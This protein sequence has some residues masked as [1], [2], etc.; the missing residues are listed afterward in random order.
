MQNKLEEIELLKKALARERAARKQAEQ[1][2]EKKSLEVYDANQQLKVLNEQLEDDVSV[3]SSQILKTES[4][5]QDLIGSASDVIFKTDNEGT[6]TYI[7]SVAEELSGFTKDD[8][9][10]NNFTFLVRDDYKVV[11]TQHFY[12]QYKSKQNSSYIE[13][14]VITK[15]GEEIWLGQSTNL[16]IEK[17]STIEFFA[18]ARNITARKKTENELMF[19]TTKLEG[20]IENL[21]AGVLVESADRKISMTNQKFCNMFSIPYTYDELIGMDCS[22]PTESSIR[23]VVNPE[24]FINNINRIAKERKLVLSDRLEMVDGSY[25]ERDYIPLFSEDK[26]IGQVWKYRDVTQRVKQTTLLQKSEEKYRSVIENLKL[27]IL[28]VDN[29]DKI[30]KAYDQFCL[31]SGYSEKELIGRSPMELLLDDNT[32]GIMSEQNVIRKKG[33]S[34]VYEVPLKTKSGEIKWVIIS[35]APYFDTNGDLLGTI[36]VHLDITERK[37]MESELIEAK[38]KAEELTKVK[39]LF[40]ANMSHEI[41]TPMNAIIGMTEILSQTN[42]SADQ[43]KYL[44][45]IESSSSNLLAL[46]NDV[47]DFSKIEMGEIHLEEIDFDLNKVML[48]IKSTISHKAEENG[49]FISINI[50]NTIPNILL[51][52][53]LKLNQVLINLLNNA[54]KFTLNGE[55]KVNVTLVSNSQNVVEIQFAV[56]DQGIGIENDELKLI[57][58]NF[59][60]AKNS[61]SREYGGTGLGLPISNKIVNLM[62][63][64]IEVDSEVDKGSTFHFVVP[65]KISKEILKEKSSVDLITDFKKASILVVE[66]NPI[67]MLMVYTILDKWNCDIHPANNG[68]EAIDM[69]TRS[70]YDL[71]LMDVQM[72]KMGGIEATNIMREKHKINTPIIAL[73]ANAI[74]GDNLKCLD[75]GMDDYISKPFKQDVLNSILN[76]WLN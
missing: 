20:I 29:N 43:K 54:V 50:D 25:L 19:N 1:I 51:G 16:I 58:E 26:F 38:V 66:D 57:F 32:K 40:L 59:K 73:T 22:T 41:R 60:Q 27:G 17:D 6:F 55:V 67:N 75:A 23:Q 21:N 63:G 31:L 76:K 48:N 10:N 62:G 36:G 15:T 3:K 65:F 52:D 53:P 5:F 69:V 30:T 74:V 39:E 13:Y 11:L 33:I 14:P 44:E 28:E 49:V 47:L 56:K 35:G 72:P 4:M 12:K 68:V 64:S 7:N 37:K 24:E 9:L 18:L 45:A 61:T 70:S 46:I 8:F 2:L 71:I 34:S 42:L